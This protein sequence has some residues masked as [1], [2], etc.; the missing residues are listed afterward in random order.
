[1]SSETKGAYGY[2]RLSG[3]GRDDS[4]DDQ[5]A[6]ISEYVRSRD[7]LS[8]VTTW[9]DGKNTSGFDAEREWYQRL[10]TK[11]LNGEIDAI[12]TRDRQRLARDFDERL[13]LITA[14]R[15]TGVEWHVVEEG[16]RL[17]LE[18]TQNAGMECLHAMMDHIKKKA[19]IQRSKDVVEQRI[20][21]GCYQG[22]PPAGLQFADDGCH[23]EKTDRWDDVVTAYAMIEDGT[24][25]STICAETGFGQSKVS[26]MRKRGI[27][28]YEQRL[29]Q[30]G[31]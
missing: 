26:R 2:T 13:A 29:E 16:G 7:D 19:E 12:V 22:K 28:W 27:D 21:D 9:G 23:L 20:E 5:K 24:A 25:N 30:Y 14:F 4:I 15:E 1:M 10:K 3:S 6:A 18:D 11:I 8:L 17:Y 31:K